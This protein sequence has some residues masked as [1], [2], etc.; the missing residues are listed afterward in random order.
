MFVFFNVTFIDLYSWIPLYYGY[1]YESTFQ[2]NEKL[3]QKEQQNMKDQVDSLTLIVRGSQ[4]FIFLF[5]MLFA[6][7]FIKIRQDRRERVKE[8]SVALNKL[9]SLNK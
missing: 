5:A 2:Y 1:P 8:A 3:T 9:R 7:I 6:W 4:L